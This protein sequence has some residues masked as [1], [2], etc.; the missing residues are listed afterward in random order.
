VAKE[1]KCINKCTNLK[2]IYRKLILKVETD[3]KS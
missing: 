1:A 2:H 3:I